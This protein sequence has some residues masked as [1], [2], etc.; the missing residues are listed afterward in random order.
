[1]ATYGLDFAK[2]YFEGKKYN[3]Y[4]GWTLQLTKSGFILYRRYLNLLMGFEHGHGI[5]TLA[6]FA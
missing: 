1:M 5:S 6:T 2:K 4:A 3:K